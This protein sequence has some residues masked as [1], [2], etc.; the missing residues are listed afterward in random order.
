VHFLD[1]GDWVERWA[2]LDR[3]WDSTNGKQGIEADGKEDEIEGK[4][5]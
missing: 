4:P 5:S 1:E 3:D 2:N